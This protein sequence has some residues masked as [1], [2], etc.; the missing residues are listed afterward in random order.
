MAT[1][2][3]AG[4]SAISS[5]HAQSAAEHE[6]DLLLLQQEAQ[7]RHTT[8]SSAFSTSS[9]DRFLRDNG[10]QLD[11]LDDDV[12]SSSA[13]GEYA[14]GAT[15]ERALDEDAAAAVEGL[16]RVE[17]SQEISGDRAEDDV[18]SISSSNS[19]SSAGRSSS[20]NG[21]SSTAAGE[22]DLP[23]PRFIL[24][25][26]EDLLSVARPSHS[27][28]SLSTVG[29]PSSERRP[30]VLGMERFVD[31]F[32]RSLLLGE[33]GLSALSEAS[34]ESEEGG[35]PLTHASPGHHR[36]LSP[37]SSSLMS[38]GSPPSSSANV[39]STRRQ[40]DELSD[41]LGVRSSLSLAQERHVPD[42]AKSRREPRRLETH[43]EEEKTERTTRVRE[44]VNPW[45]ED[46]RTFDGSARG[47]GEAQ[48]AQ[49]ADLNVLLR[50]N[51]LPTLE[52]RELLVASR[53]G[54]RLQA[55]VVP[56]HSSLVTLVQ[57]FILQLDRKNE[58]IQ[59]LIIHSNRNN[60]DQTKAE[61]GLASMERKTE[62]L[63]K[64]LQS[65]QS[66]IARLQDEVHRQKEETEKQVKV[67]KSSCLKLQQQLKVSEHRVK[68][69]EVLV[70]RM[71]KKMQQQVEKENQGKARDRKIFQQLQQREPRKS[72]IK[73][74]QSLECI[75]VYETQREQMQQEIDHLRNHVT[76]LNSELRDKENSLSRQSSL[77]SGVW[78]DAGARSVHNSRASDVPDEM[79]LRLEAARREQEQ[80][81]A[82]L[83]Q[84]EAIMVKKI[85]AI[86]EELLSARETIAELKDEN[87]N[88]TLEAESRPSIRDYRLAQRRIHQLERQ[89][90][91]S[92]LAVEEANDI[93]ELRRFMGTTELIE[94]DRLNH[95]LHL[96]RLSTLPKET[97]LE[98]VKEVCRVL[99][100][101]D[102][103]LITP[104]LHKLCNV[105]TAVPR[106]EKFIR[107]VCGFVYF[108]TGDQDR[109]EERFE[110]EQVLPT[111]QQWMVERKKLHDLEGFKVAVVAELCKRSVEPSLL[112]NESRSGS[113]SPTHL[114][115]LPRAVQMVA[116]LVELEKSVLHHREI[117][118]QAAEELEHRPSVLVNQIV[119][120]FSQVFQ[121][122]SV[123]GVLPKINEIY[124]FV[125]EM[126]NFLKVTRALL[127]LKPDITLP[128]LA[129]AIRSLADGESTIAQP[130]P[131]DENANTANYVVEKPVRG[132]VGAASGGVEG[133][134]QVREMSVLIRDLKK[135][136]G[137]AT[138]HEILPR[139]RRLME[140]LSMSIHQSPA[141]DDF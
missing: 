27:A 129:D 76:A 66:E 71:Q 91:E 118:T 12:L 39:S 58:T 122:K 64:A 8:G 92:K 14:M 2:L 36:R 52:L 86:E 108:N 59:D 53:H 25:D 69:K 107:D 67:V 32:D 1:P 88:L 61:D 114:S 60:K 16:L 132:R 37:S 74:T 73:D 19:S 46:S 117:Y 78:S 133:V 104:S 140:L 75:G 82:K 126:Q 136:L 72:S 43:E 134:R 77:G 56:D 41:A 5:T 109:A 42:S 63:R 20:S 21:H 127:N 4:D 40:D 50:K 29:R 102:I 93:Q 119:R 35:G 15:P 100:L 105:V 84:R 85:S 30:S 33:A 83:R 120:H 116:E 131:Q 68:A 89:L 138:M 130:Q 13:D 80:A 28:A 97:L 121:V 128:A 6:E 137:A 26:D 115:S 81:A 34:R 139:T 47:E 106:M 70:E 17:S 103:T 141:E 18:L 44:A 48:R 111:L 101:T 7:L 49:W 112:R 45:H 110:L 24:L 62:E 38:L 96:N 54:Q 123:E 9:V 57:E 90:S 98:V 11:E 113:P 135:E 99:N 3:H 124:L 23:T 95:R 87:S 22:G 94:R 51:G 10:F 125:N 65:S 55:S 79:L 31:S